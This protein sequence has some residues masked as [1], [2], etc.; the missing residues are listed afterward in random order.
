MW[1]TGLKCQLTSLR[2]SRDCPDL[3]GVAECRVHSAKN[4]SSLINKCPCRLT[5]ALEIHAGRASNGCQSHRRTH[6][7]RYF[8]ERAGPSTPRVTEPLTTSFGT[9]GQWVLSPGNGGQT[10]W[11]LK[12]FG[13]FVQHG[14]TLKSLGKF[15]RRMRL[16]QITVGGF[17]CSR[18]SSPLLHFRPSTEHVLCHDELAVFVEVPPETVPAAVVTWWQCSP[19]AVCQR[20]LVGL[21]RC[22]CPASYGGTCPVQML[23]V[24]R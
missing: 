9:V 18:P 24:I 6:A 7:E 2:A 22:R 23:G 19:A 21:V 12:S 15:S 20:Y 10:G 13:K 14:W 4:P 3:L 16:S 11:P 1:R 8:H 17:V 5:S